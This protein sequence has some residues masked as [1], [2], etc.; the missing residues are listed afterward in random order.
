MFFE[1]N[2]AQDE[3]FRKSVPVLDNENGRQPVVCVM[4]MYFT[5]VIKNMRNL[6]PFL[7]TV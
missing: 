1:I 5:V 2:Q 4:E 3:H 7:I 6:Q